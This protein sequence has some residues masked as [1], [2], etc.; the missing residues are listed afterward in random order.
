M[1]VG[2]EI[3][4]GGSGDP[5]HGKF[6]NIAIQ[7]RD[8]SHFATELQDHSSTP[9]NPAMVLG[10]PALSATDFDGNTGFVT[11][12]F[13]GIVFDGPGDDVV[14]HLT[15]FQPGQQFIEDFFLDAS[16][17]GVSF[18]QIGY[19][20]PNDFT[21]GPTE[22]VALPFDL[23]A[24][25]LLTAK[26]IRL[27]NAQ[28]F[29]NTSS[30]GP[31]VLAFEALHLLQM[32]TLGLSKEITGGPDL[33]NRLDSDDTPDGEIDLVVEIKQSQTTEYDF[34]I[35]YSNEGVETLVLD[36]VPVKWQI[37]EVNGTAVIDGFLNS[38]D[39]NGGIG[40]VA[41]FPKN[42]QPNNKSST[43][44]EWRPD[45]SLSSSTLNVVVETRGKAQDKKGVVFN[46]KGCGPLLLNKG[47]L[48]L[49]INPAT[50]DVKRDPVTGDKLP[51]LFESSALVLAGLE[52]VDGDGIIFRDGIGDEDGDGLTDIQEVREFGSNPCRIDSDGDGLTDAQEVAAGTDL[53]NPDTDGD[54][55]ADGSD[56]DPLDPAIQ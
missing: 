36:N 3:G 41:V 42:G 25:G 19:L 16:D 27:R 45:P 10:P 1:E 15:G 48:A 22:H 9:W 38:D 20:N 23:A 50:G 39:G 40:T 7:I 56:S 6:D 47:S 49:E 54:G 51:P 32:T 29:S 55:V 52:D 46:P 17:D 2:V 18:V 37:T 30:E 14:V 8:A 34:T 11:V 12:G 21:F 31:D 43:G 53:T 24:G 33:P 4:N 13:D 35:T 26:S 28:A 44:I 5:V